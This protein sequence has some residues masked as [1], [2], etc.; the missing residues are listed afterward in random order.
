MRR[1]TNRHT[2]ATTT[3]ITIRF[4]VL[5][6]HCISF[7]DDGHRKLRWNHGRYFPQPTVTSKCFYDPAFEQLRLLDPVGASGRRCESTRLHPYVHL[8]CSSTGFIQE[9]CNLKNSK[10]TRLVPRL[11]T[12]QQLIKISQSQILK[13]YS[14]L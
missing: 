14:N 2:S 13:F 6:L 8:L 7:P 12:I 11:R 1:F 4:S 3:I 10:I 5:L 9:L